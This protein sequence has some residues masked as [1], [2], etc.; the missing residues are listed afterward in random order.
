MNMGSLTTEEHEYKSLISIGV[1]KDEE[2]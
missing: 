2:L 1:I